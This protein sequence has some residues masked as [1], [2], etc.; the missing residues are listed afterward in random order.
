MSISDLKDFVLDKLE[1]EGSVLVI[2]NTV[3][4]AIDV[5]DSFANFTTPQQATDPWASLGI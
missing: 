2:L 3:K 5:F 4:C 1:T